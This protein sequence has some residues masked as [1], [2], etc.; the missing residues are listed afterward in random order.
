FDVPEPYASM[1]G[2]ASGRD[3]FTVWPPYTDSEGLAK[4]MAGTSEEE[5]AFV[6]SQYFGKLA[7]VDRWLGVLLDRLDELSLSLGRD[8]RHTHHRPRPRPG[9]ARRLW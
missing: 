3:R 1:F 5:L 7:M 9:R 2:D 4:F 6:Q 8:G